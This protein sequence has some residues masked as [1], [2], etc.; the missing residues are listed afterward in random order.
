M[1]KRKKALQPE[2]GARRGLFCD[3]ETSNFANV[4]QL[5]WLAAVLQHWPWWNWSIECGI[6][7]SWGW[8]D[9]VVTLLASWETAAPQ[10]YFQ[11]RLCCTMI[12]FI[13]L[14]FIMFDI[15][16]CNMSG[17]LI[18][19]DWMIRSDRSLHLMITNYTSSLGISLAYLWQP[20]ACLLV[21]SNSDIDVHQYSK[22]SEKV[23]HLLV[24]S[25]Y[26]VDLR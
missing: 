26:Y 23:Q 8:R 24:E 2:A 3:C 11:C 9:G 4:R 21:F 7:W 18:F 19:T 16:I 13:W 14:Y 6:A 12:Y 25:S 15:L 5:Y 17:Y 10:F 20:T 22:S 1:W